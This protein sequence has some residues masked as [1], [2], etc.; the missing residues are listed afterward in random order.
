ML[1]FIFTDKVPPFF[2]SKNRQILTVVIDPNQNVVTATITHFTKFTLFAVTTPGPS[3][4]GPANN[5]RLATMGTTLRW[6][7]PL[8][9]TQYQLQVSPFNNDGPG[10]DLLV[11]DSQW[12]LTLSSPSRPLS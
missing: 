7:S 9:A 3:L 4:L 12:W 2:P 10:L 5:E 8:G 11:G 6:S 1:L